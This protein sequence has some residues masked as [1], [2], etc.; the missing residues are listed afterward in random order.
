MWL[1]VAA[2]NP[3]IEQ[4]QLLDAP[5]FAI[6]MERLRVAGYDHIVIDA[7]AVLGSADVNLM[8]DAA[9]GVILTA[10][11]RRTTARD[12]RRSV[13]QLGASTVIGTVL[14]ED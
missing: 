1:H 8:A 5:A 6:A 11:A 3:R 12:L 7:P 14:V 13:D 10:R 9:D 4:S 2:I